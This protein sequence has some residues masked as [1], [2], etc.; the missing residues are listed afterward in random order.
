MQAAPQDVDMTQSWYDLRFRESHKVWPQL[1]VCILSKVERC[2]I[3]LIQYISQM[4][5]M[6][7]VELHVRLESHIYYRC[8]L[9]LQI[10]NLLREFDGVF[11]LT[12]LLDDCIT[13]RLDVII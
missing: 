4:L 13:G 8:N 3:H 5:L 10:K 11:S 6:C 12:L 2:L 9:K 7:Q 1:L